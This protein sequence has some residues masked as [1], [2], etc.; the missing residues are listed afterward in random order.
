[1][2][3]VA[4]SGLPSFGRLAEEGEEI[5]AQAR[6][7]QQDIRELHIGLLNM[8]P[9]AALAATERQFMR[10]IGS[11]NRIAQFYVHP[12]TVGGIGRGAEAEAYIGR[13]YES[14]D[15]IRAQG[16]DA[17]IITGA[18]I[19]NPDFTQEPFWGPLS[20][21]VEWAHEQVTTTL[22]ACLAA[23]ATMLMKYGVHR[24]R[25]PDKA[26]GVFPHRVVD[27]RHPLVRNINTR[28]D[29]PHS[30]WNEI[31]R[32]QLDDAGLVTLVESAE[33]GPHLVVSPDGFRQVFFQGHPEYDIDSLL[34]E[35]KRE[36]LRY[37][38]GER[39]DYPPLVQHYFP[40]AAQTLL[41]EYKNHVFQQQDHGRQPDGSDFPEAAV[42]RLLD[43]TWADTAKAIFNNWLGLMYQITGHERAVPFM[44]GVDPDDTLNG[45]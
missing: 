35:Y 6:A 45:L 42:L 29:V 34:K 17:L 25:L 10:L 12:F 4:H 5:L 16:L 19:S 2:P 14:F 24:R 26:W 31:T 40:E 18:N 28:F 7:A 20:E 11:S 43:N 32:E 8:M 39:A 37:L 21:V 22:F 15:T 36:V 33:V 13:W 23:H 27:R 41:Y 30:R 44:P 9:D 1:M 3:L 38:H